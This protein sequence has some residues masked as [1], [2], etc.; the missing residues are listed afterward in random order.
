MHCSKRQQ[1]RKASSKSRLSVRDGTA[2]SGILTPTIIPDRV[3]PDTGGFYAKFRG[4]EGSVAWWLACKDG[5]EGTASRGEAE[6]RLQI[7]LR[8]TDEWTPT[9]DECGCI[10]QRLWANREKN[11]PRYSARTSDES[12]AGNGGCGQ[13]HSSSCCCSREDCSLSFFLANALI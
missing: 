7:T 3:S 11:K 5:W 2:S 6:V 10:D 9:S 13:L 1:T 4:Q 12:S 8:C